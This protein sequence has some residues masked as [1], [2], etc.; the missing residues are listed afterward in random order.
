[1]TE[2]MNGNNMGV[3]LP[4]AGHRERKKQRTREKLIDAALR[5]FSERGYEETRIDDIVA[6]VDLV[7]RTFF[8]YFSS[9]D[10]ALF[11]FHEQAGEDAIAALLARPR[12]EGIVTALIVSKMEVAKAHL[13]HTRIITV[14]HD[15]AETSPEIRERLAALRDDLQHELARVLA[16]RLPPS[17]TLIAEMMSAAISAAFVFAAD[18]WVE[19]GGGRTLLE[20]WGA[21][22]AKALKLFEEIDHRYVLR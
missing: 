9:K 14:I 19:D 8:R 7:P 10:D 2:F 21:A 13:E 5:L 12:G 16:G 22:A 11:G 17:S 20:C 4:S 18:R 3:S 6:E 15:L 1:M